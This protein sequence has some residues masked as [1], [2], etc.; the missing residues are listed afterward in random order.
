MK[1]SIS[2]F[3]F[4]PFSVAAS[5][6]I[7]NG[8]CAW[9]ALWRRRPVLALGGMPLA[10]AYEMAGRCQDGPESA[11]EIKMKREKEKKNGT[12]KRS[13]RPVANQ[14]RAAPRAFWVWESLVA[15]LLHR[16]AFYGFGQVPAR[17]SQWLHCAELEQRKGE[18]GRTERGREERQR[19]ESSSH[20]PCTK[21][22]SQ[23]RVEHAHTHPHTHKAGD[24]EAGQRAEMGTRDSDME[25]AESQSGQK[26]RKDK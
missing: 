16:L 12:E 21:H 6:V 4:I 15:F 7:S 2:L 10:G 25:G 11:S 24:K 3:P 26:G 14:R 1:C 9:T 23:Y 5:S 8:N 19:D 22:T 17:H 18:R 13:T 20:C